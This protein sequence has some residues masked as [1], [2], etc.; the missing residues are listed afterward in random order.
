MLIKVTS[1]SAGC[2]SSLSL[3]DP[4]GAAYSTTVPLPHFECGTPPLLMVQ[5]N[6]TPTAAVNDTISQS[7]ILN[8]VC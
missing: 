1:K 8:M 6:Q 5:G 4:K 3:V 2:S 7:H